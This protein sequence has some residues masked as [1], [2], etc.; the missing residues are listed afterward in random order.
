MTKPRRILIVSYTFPPSGGIGGR[1]WAKF[2]KSLI[3]KGMLVEVVSADIPQYDRNPWKEDVK[4]IPVHRFVSKFPIVLTTVPDGFVAKVRYRL[5][6]MKMKIHT[7][8]TPYD[9]AALDRDSVR[10]V[11]ARSMDSFKPDFVVVTG[12]PFDLLNH[13]SGLIPRYSTTKFLADLRDPWINGKAFGYSDLP[14]GRL[15]V[16]K[17]KEREVIEAYHR[18]TM[19]WEKNIEELSERYPDYKSKFQVLPHFYDEDE[20]SHGDEMINE[21]PDFL[22]GGALYEGLEPVL[23]DLA[24]F[25]EQHELKAEILTDDRE[26]IPIENDWFRIKPLMPSRR[27]FALAK[28]SK[29]LILFLPEGNRHGLTKLIEYAACD[30]PILAIGKPGALGQM[31]ESLGL[32]KFVDIA[33]LGQELKDLLLNPYVHNPDRVWIARHAL[34]NVTNKLMELLESNSNG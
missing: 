23:A 27:F 22:Y 3:R 14:D 16:E 25:C 9:R 33:N 28:S 17:R 4:G 13:L 19:P 20:I 1:R 34:S 29:F 24:G 2:A 32:G 10:E 26:K 31:I 5:A 6:L 15:S 7:D 12:A 30:K 18:V 8:G 21:T 11:F